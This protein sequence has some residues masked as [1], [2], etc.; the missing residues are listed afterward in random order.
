MDRLFQFSVSWL[1]VIQIVF[2]V[3]AVVMALFAIVLLVFG[4]LATGATRQNVYSGRKCIM[5]GRVSAGFFILM[6]FLLI[7]GW[8]VIL[9]V[10]T[11]PVFLYIMFG[12]ICNTEV[13]GKNS[14]KIDYV[15]EL[16]HY[17]I[18]K[19]TTYPL[20]GANPP[21]RD[22]IDTPTELRNLCDNFAEAGPLFCTAVAGAACIIFGMIFYMAILSANYTRIKI[23]KE[24]TDYRNAV[25]MEEIDLHSNGRGILDQS[26]DKN[27][28]R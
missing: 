15:F 13:Y 20:F 17:G 10:S 5:G 8:L 24:L 9:G 6:S 27:S 2:I 18:Y 16:R 4:F 25:D 3:V 21:G 23:S 11:I 26:Y 22:K 1:S 14:E 19:N 28:F 12:S 7:M